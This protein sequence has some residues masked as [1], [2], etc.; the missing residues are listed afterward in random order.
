MALACCIRSGISF[1][2]TITISDSVSSAKSLPS[3][4][5]LIPAL[6]DYRTT[7]AQKNVKIESDLSE[8][9]EA[10]KTSPTFSQFTK[11]PLVPR[12]TRLAAIVDVC[13]K[14]KFPE[15]TKNFL[16]FLAEN[17]KLK[18]LDLKT[19]HRGN[20]K[21]LVTTVMTFGVIICEV[22]TMEKAQTAL[23]LL[24]YNKN[25]FNLVIRDVDMPWF[26]AT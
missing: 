21:V 22:A 11:D 2:K 15:P 7:S 1:F 23:E 3:G 10:I 19:A 18:N 13:E 26:Q 14:A 24:R 20:V 16:S 12:E 9:V 5:P 6:R 25:K 4:H 17:G 8:L